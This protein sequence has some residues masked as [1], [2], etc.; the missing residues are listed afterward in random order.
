MFSFLN[1][2]YRIKYLKSRMNGKLISVVKTSFS[3]RSVIITAN[4][5]K[6]PTA[7]VT[8]VSFH[9]R[10]DECFGNI[11]KLFSRKSHNIF[12]TTKH[13]TIL[14]YRNS[15]HTSCRTCNVHKCNFIPPKVFHRCLRLGSDC[16]VVQ[17]QSGFPRSARSR[18]LGPV[19]R[20]V[21]NDR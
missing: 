5:T 3:K 19:Y 18:S 6:S 4:E 9:S 11:W 14:L 16:D 15:K 10:D 13:C 12:P 21:Q 8:I 7:I 20:L 17:K 2:D 1:S